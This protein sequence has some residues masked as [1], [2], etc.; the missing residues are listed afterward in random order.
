MNICHILQRKCF[1]YNR[2]VPPA[3]IWFDPETGTTSLLLTHARLGKKPGDIYLN[4]PPVLNDDNILIS[5]S[6]D[7]LENFVPKVFERKTFMD[8]AL[9]EYIN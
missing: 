9:A 5:K 3:G 4:I 7:S 2:H 6:Y 8:K 1:N